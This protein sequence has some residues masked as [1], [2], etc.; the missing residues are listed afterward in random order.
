[1]HQNKGLEMESYMNFNENL[2][3]DICNIPG[4]VQSLCHEDLCKHGPE[5]GR[6]DCYF[7]RHD[8]LSSSKQLFYNNRPQKTNL[9]Y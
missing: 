9:P 6:R 4:N 8:N 1:M 5:C 2:Q 7:T 3:I